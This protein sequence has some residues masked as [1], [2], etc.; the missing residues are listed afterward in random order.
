[1]RKT[2]AILSG[3]IVLICLG[4]APAG[5]SL[6]DFTAPSWSGANGQNSFTVSLPSFGFDITV[7]ASGGS[8]LYWDNQDGLGIR[9][10]EPDEVDHGERLTVS[11]SRPVSLF[12]FGLTDLFSENGYLERGFYNLD[13]GSTQSFIADPGQPSGSSNGLLLVSLNGSLVSGFELWALNPVPSGQH[14]DFSLGNV[15]ASATP[16]PASVALLASA[17]GAGLLWRRRRSA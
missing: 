2:F 15:S 14:H 13:G 6:I 7:T 17:L 5:A 1:M 4:G 12:S 9:G 16:E 3:L 8:S 11:F 10:G